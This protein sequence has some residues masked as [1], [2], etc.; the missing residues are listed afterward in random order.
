MFDTIEA[1]VIAD[2]E[3]DDARLADATG[4]VYTQ[5]EGSA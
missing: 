5:I 4:V 2:A 3:G 1:V